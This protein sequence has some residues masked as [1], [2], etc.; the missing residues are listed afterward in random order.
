SLVELRWKTNVATGG[1]IHAGAGLGPYSPTTLT[2]V[3]SPTGT[4]T[5]VQST[6]QYRLGGSNGVLWQD[7]DSTNLVTTIPASSSQTTV[8]VSGNADPW[9]ERAG[10]KQDLASL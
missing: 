6:D 5:G 4:A 1:R 8:V 10:V 3:I 9:T 2:V 7:I